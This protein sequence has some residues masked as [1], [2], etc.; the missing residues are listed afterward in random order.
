M[1][2]VEADAGAHRGHGRTSRYRVL[3]RLNVVVGLLLA[4]EATWM[5]LASNDLA[6]PVTASFLR[7]DPVTVIGPTLPQRVLSLQIGPIVAVFLLLAAAD[8]LLVAAPW[9]HRWYE[10]WLDRR[11]SYARWIEYSVSASIMIVL[12]GFFVSIR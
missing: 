2:V 10:R 12:I 9:V 6:L 5:L 3:R 7:V 11:T 8:H 1:P 4:A